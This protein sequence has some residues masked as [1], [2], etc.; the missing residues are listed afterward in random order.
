MKIELVEDQ[1]GNTDPKAN[2]RLIILQTELERF[3]FLVRSYLRARISKIDAYALHHL[4]APDTKAKLSPSEVQYATAHTTL[5]HQHYRASFLSQFPAYLQRMDDSQGGVSMVET[6]D[7]DK[8][9]F[10]RGL[11][12][13]G[14]VWV[15]G[16]D[17]AFEMRRGDVFVVRWAAVKDVVGRGDAE[18]I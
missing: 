18:L 5:L 7:T 14:E 9:V 11:R 13:V 15:E 4:T 12:D 17:T 16:T 3:K 8:A 1:T 10:V 6:P 2:F